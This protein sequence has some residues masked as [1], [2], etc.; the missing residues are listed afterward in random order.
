MQR[1]IFSL[2]AW[3]MPDRVRQLISKDER[4]GLMVSAFTRRELGFGFTVSEDILDEVNALRHE[5]VTPKYCCAL[6]PPSPLHS[7]F[8]S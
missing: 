5:E 4:Y 6:Q 1:N 8:T 7:I 2:F 3:T